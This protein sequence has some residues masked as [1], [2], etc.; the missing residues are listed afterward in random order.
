LLFDWIVR[1]GFGDVIVQGNVGGQM[2]ASRTTRD[3][4]PLRVNVPALRVLAKGM[5][6]NWVSMSRTLDV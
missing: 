3:A 5:D 1:S 6:Y 4:Q 2:A